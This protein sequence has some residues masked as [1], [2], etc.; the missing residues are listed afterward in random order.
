MNARN[1]T[2]TAKTPYSDVLHRPQT[3]GHGGL[4][5]EL[6]QLHLFVDDVWTPHVVFRVST[7]S[8]LMMLT[9]IGNASLIAVIVGQPSLRRKRVSIFLINLAVGDLMVCLVTMTTE[10]AFVAFGQWV[11]GAVA[12]KLVVYG[13][14]VTLAST[15]F[16][17][18][19][20]S[21][22]RYQVSRDIKYKSQDV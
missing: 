8:L 16:L 11:L 15:T 5:V 4:S 13:E 2:D 6:E 19:A 9:L 20:M 18:T 12:C 10:I 14:I 21:I 17:L 3:H 7:I 1:S 22:D